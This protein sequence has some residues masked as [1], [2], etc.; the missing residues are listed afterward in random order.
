MR[1][2]DHFFP[3]RDPADGARNREQYGEHRG[4]EAHRLQRDARIEIDVGIELLF[5]EI[6]VVQGNLFELHGDVEQRIVLDT[7][8]GENLMAG[9]LHDLGARIVVLVNA[10]PKSHQA[11]GII[12][13][14]G[15][16]DEFRNAADRSNFAQHVECGFIGAA[17]RRTPETRASGGNAGERIGAGGAGKPHCRGRC[18]LFVIG[19]QNKNAVHGARQDRVWLVLLGRHRVAHAQEVGG[20]V[21]IV[22]RINER[23]TDRIFVRHGSERRNLRNHADRSDH[24]LMR[25]GDVGGVVVEGG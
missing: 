16:L 2:L 19:V 22:F 25:I 8:F 5:D 6:L 14:L 17:M 4:R 15:T 1:I 23:L 18:V 24:A 20:V 21:E 13:V 9:L 3:L 10:V 12:L 7:E 11:V